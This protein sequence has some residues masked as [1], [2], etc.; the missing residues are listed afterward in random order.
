MKRTGLLLAIML[1]IIANL[2]ALSGVWYN[3]GGAP[4]AVVTL[5]ERELRM[6]SSDEDDSGVALRFI[7]QG[8]DQEELDNEPWLDRAKL[9]QL[10][11]DIPPAGHDQH[12][13]DWRVVF[14]VMELR[15]E[16][17][18][19]SRLFPIDAGLDREELLRAYGNSPRAFVA[20]GVV[21]INYDPDSDDASKMTGQV[22]RLLPGIIHVPKAHAAYLAGL[23]GRAEEPV[24]PR[25]AVTL[26]YG[27]RLEPW[28]VKVEPLTPE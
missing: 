20:P 19:G 17:E 22:Q 1:V 5:T 6:V 28:V 21:R 16:T 4:T 15:E 12:F 23:G 11:F 27:R 10:G 14:V 26:R 8:L 13:H 3:R 18:T 25:Y 24:P 7:W 2:A 9:E